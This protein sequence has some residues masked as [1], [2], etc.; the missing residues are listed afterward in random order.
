[1]DWMQTEPSKTQPYKIAMQPE[2]DLVAYNHPCT[3]KEDFLCHVEWKLLWEKFHMFS[4]TF[5]ASKKPLVKGHDE[6]QKWAMLSSAMLLISLFTI[7]NRDEK[8]T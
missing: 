3:K 5:S 7:T 2:T 6:I 8:G 1:M 4:N